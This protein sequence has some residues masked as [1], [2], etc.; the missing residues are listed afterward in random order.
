[1]GVKEFWGEQAAPFTLEGTT[2]QSH[3]PENDKEQDQERV[4]DV[5]DGKPG[6]SARNTL[7]IK[8]HGIDSIHQPTLRSRL[9]L[10]LA[11][12]MLGL[13]IS[14]I[15]WVIWSRP[16]TKTPAPLLKIVPITSFQGNED[17]A[18]FSPEGK[19]VAFVWNGEKEDNSDIYV[20]LLGAETPLRLTTDPA[21]DVN[22]AWSPDGRQIAFL[23]QSAKNGGFYLIPALGGSERKLA[24]AFPYHPIT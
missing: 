19:Q 13:L 12:L 6:F 16:V 8:S 17:Q 5:L 24:E 14:I 7:D 22:P 15:F 9:T 11:F 18:A 4:A 20:K 10:P 1:A 21:P 23:R 3:S 2:L